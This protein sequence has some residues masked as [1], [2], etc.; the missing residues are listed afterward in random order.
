MLGVYKRE[1]ICEEAERRDTGDNPQS[2]LAE[3]QPRPKGETARNFGKCRSNICDCRQ[4]PAV[5]EKPFMTTMPEMISPMPMTAAASS[6][7]PWKNQ[8]IVAI[9]TMPTPDQIA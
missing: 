9:N 2:R 5:F 6:F 4:C 3:A 1:E 7:W 8:A